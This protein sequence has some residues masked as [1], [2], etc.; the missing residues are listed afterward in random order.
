MSQSV[1]LIEGWDH[2]QASLATTKGWSS[3]P[4]SVQ[5]GRLAGQCARLGS[6]TTSKNFPGTYTT[7]ICGFAFRINTIGVTTTAIFTLRATTT[8]TCQIV[9]TTLGKLEVRNSSNT[10]IATST[11]TLAANNWYFIE[12]KFVINGAS[13][14]VRLDING[15]A[16]IGTTTGNFGSTGV[17]NVLLTSS[18]GGVNYDFDDIR[19]G[20]GTTG[21]LADFLGDTR[22]EAIVPTADG[23]SEAWTPS[24]G[25]DSYALVDE[26]SGTFPNGDTDYLS[27]STANQRSTFD[28]G[29]LSVSAGSVYALQ[30]NMYARKDD[31]GTREIASVIRHGG[32][33]YDGT[34]KSLSTTYA[35][36]SQVYEAMPNADALSISNVNAAEFGIKLV[37]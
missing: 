4:T 1:V 34:T 8:N 21:S 14:S 20:N 18:G 5:T 10:T 23:A 36:Y 6:T 17:D 26:M 32:T 12:A 28:M 25:S 29:T 7:A 27:S 15:G 3:N 33:D 31:A 30:T 11:V 9:I 37:T 2:F 13:G 16:D 22:V 35:Y 19:V 24:T